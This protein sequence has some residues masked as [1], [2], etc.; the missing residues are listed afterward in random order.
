MGHV[1]GYHT[2]HNRGAICTPFNINSEVPASIFPLDTRVCQCL[3]NA[4]YG[5]VSDTLHHCKNTVALGG[6]R[7]QGLRRAKR[8]QELEELNV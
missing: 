5:V 8:A 3:S 6:Q 7:R 2:M 1:F 4:E